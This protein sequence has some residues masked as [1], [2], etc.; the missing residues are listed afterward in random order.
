MGFDV[1]MLVYVDVFIDTDAGFVATL[2]AQSGVVGK[3]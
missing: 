3:I 1:E 2:F